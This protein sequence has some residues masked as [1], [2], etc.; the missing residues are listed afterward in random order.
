MDY[1]VEVRRRFAAALAAPAQNT[2]DSEVSAS[3]ESE[4]RALAV[5]VRARIGVSGER[6]VS[7][8]FDVWGCPDTIAAATLAAERIR[9]A[10]LEDFRGLDVHVLAEDLGIPTEKLGKLL[11]L[12]DAALAATARAREQLK[13]GID[14]GS[15]TD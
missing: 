4:D 7:A 8:A 10:A 1:S 9:D 11:R 5:W 3:A 14:N 2:L 12:E 13:K 6:I 15:I